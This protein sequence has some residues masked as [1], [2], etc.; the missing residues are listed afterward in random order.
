MADIHS[1]GG[2]EGVVVEDMTSQRGDDDAGMVD[3]QAHALGQ[4]AFCASLFWSVRCLWVIF[5]EG[6]GKL[7]Q[8]AAVALGKKAICVARAFQSDC[9]F[10]NGKSALK[11]AR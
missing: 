5:K 4:Q 1:V 11:T 6:N 3:M 7:D 10:K 8:A 9:V 2:D